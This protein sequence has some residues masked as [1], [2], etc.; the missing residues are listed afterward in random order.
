MCKGGFVLCDAPSGDEK[1]ESLWVRM[2]GKVN[3]ADA[4]VGV[5]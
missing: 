4:V 2:K 5:Y 3:K 1:V